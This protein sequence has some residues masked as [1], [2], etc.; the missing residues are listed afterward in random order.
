M[1]DS[2][3]A[4]G[5]CGASSS[6]SLCSTPERPRVPAAHILG[7]RIACPP[8]DTIVE[9]LQGALSS[10]PSTTCC[11]RSTAS[12]RWFTC[13]H[14]GRVRSMTITT[15]SAKG[16]VSTRR[17]SSSRSTPTSR[18]RS[19]SRRLRRRRSSR[20]IQEM[21]DGSQ[22]NCSVAVAVAVTVRPRPRSTRWP[23]APSTTSAASTPSPSTLRRTRP[24]RPT[25]RRPSSPPTRT[26]TPSQ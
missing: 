4:Q 11:R 24:G 20:S 7:A 12:T 5:A 23:T 14:S 13:L 21:R 26:D 15:R 10:P 2:R 25:Q 16:S 19:P 22:R 8:R 1:L 6:V 17:R 18:C 9:L 3:T